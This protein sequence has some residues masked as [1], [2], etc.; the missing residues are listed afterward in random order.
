MRAFVIVALLGSGSAALAQPGM[1]P[2]ESDVERAQRLENDA[3][4]A[5]QRLRAQ[6]LGLGAVARPPRP[7]V[8]AEEPGVAPDDDAVWVAGEWI[9]E[10]AHWV[11][12]GGRWNRG[13]MIGGNDTGWYNDDAAAVRDH[14]KSRTPTFH[15]HRDRS[16]V[17]DHRRGDRATFQHDTRDDPPPPRQDSGKDRDDDRSSSKPSSS[18][19]TEWTPSSGS[20]GSSNVRD[21]RD[22]DNDR[23]DSPK[24]RDHRK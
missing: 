10:L 4:R 9:W 11:W 20:S 2:P 1:T 8:L 3:M 19:E 14:R 12:R 23:D 15:D 5:R 18:R 7:A 22:R 24:V 13:E 21:H 6:L 17:R 16:A